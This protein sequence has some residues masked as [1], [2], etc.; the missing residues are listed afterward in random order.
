[1][2]WGGWGSLSASNSLASIA[3]D[4]VIDR[5]ERKGDLSP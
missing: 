1:M 3:V 4:G 2:G 5:L